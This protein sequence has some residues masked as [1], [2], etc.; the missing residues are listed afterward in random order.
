[1]KVTFILPSTGHRPIGGFKVV[2]EYANH[3]QRR[4]YNVAVVHPAF[5][6]ADTPWRHKPK[7]WLRYVQRRFDKSYM[8]GTWFSVE[9]AVRMLWVPSLLEKHIPQAD[10][11]VATSWQTAE[12]VAQYGADKG[13]KLYLIQ[14]YEHFMSTSPTIRKRMAATYHRGMANITISPAISEA[15]ESTGA[16]VA[17]YI[18]IA[19]DTDIFRLT[20]VLQSDNRQRIG[21][22]AR[23]EVFKG[24]HDAVRV[25]EQ[26]RQQL[27]PVSVWSFGGKKPDYFPDW[28][29]YHE[30]PSNAALCDLYNQSAVFLTTSHYE[31]WGLPGSEAMACGAALVSTNHGGVRAYATNE[32]TALLS[33]VKDVN[34]LTQNVIRLLTQ[35]ELRLKIAQA[36]YLHIQQFT[37]QTAVESL[38]RVMLGG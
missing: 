2:Y 36:G 7:K 1:L 8:P 20:Q 33:N 13:K 6:M 22:P 27:G 28:I 29:D 18:P 14:D 25:L 10:I 9:P 38:E 17:A 35:P 16:M 5:L 23:N 4:G 31:G 37:W 15:V 34:H 19:L 30:R 26:V 3:L 11:V 24:T 21:F 12:F 32:E